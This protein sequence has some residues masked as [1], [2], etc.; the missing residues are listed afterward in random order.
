MNSFKNKYF[1]EITQR[2][3]GKCEIETKLEKT[4]IYYLSMKMNGNSCKKNITNEIKNVSFSEIQLNDYIDRKQDFFGKLYSIFELCDRA[5]I[6]IY[7]SSL[8][9]EDPRVDEYIEMIND[10]IEKYILSEEKY[11]EKLLNVV[12]IHL[13][14]NYNRVI[15]K[16][17]VAGKRYFKKIINI[18]SD[19]DTKNKKFPVFVFENKNKTKY[20]SFDRYMSDLGKKTTVKN[21]EELSRKKITKEIVIKSHTIDELDKIN[22]TW[23]YKYYIESSFCLYN[24]LFQLSET[25][26]MNSIVN[27]FIL[28]TPLTNILI[29]KYKN[30]TK[31]NNGESIENK[32]YSYI[33]SEN[34]DIEDQLHIVI[35]QLFTINNKPIEKE[36]NIVEKM[37]DKMKGTIKEFYND[38]DNNFLK[39]LSG[40]GLLTLINKLKLN[41]KISYIDF[42]SSSMVDTTGN[43]KHYKYDPEKRDFS[44]SESIE[45]NIDEISKMELIKDKN[46][47]EGYLEIIRKHISK[48]ILVIVGDFKENIYMKNFI[49]IGSIFNVNIKDKITYSIIGIKC[50]IDN[51][52]YIYDSNNIIAQ[53]DWTDR[54]YGNYIEKASRFHGVTKDK[55]IMENILCFIY[56]KIKQ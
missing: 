46:K 17:D 23:W 50:N 3:K 32:N 47:L 21:M 53:D 31:L 11:L 9:C 52:Y 39:N 10:T 25:G 14:N 13:T 7:F 29:K 27:L 42:V 38:T 18:I 40:F 45:E 55:I 20:I 49:L 56:L 34:L 33:F 4:N 37:A 54:Q 16:I 22:E 24:K 26:W 30:K 36:K 41:D 19:D 48:K 5:N 1:D 51:N 12:I 15:F 35:Y 6:M 8:D 2:G 44:I 43:Y 28:I